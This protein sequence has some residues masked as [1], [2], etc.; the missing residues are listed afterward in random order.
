VNVVHTLRKLIRTTISTEL[1]SAVPPRLPREDG[2]VQAPTSAPRV[3]VV[4]SQTRYGRLLDGATHE[5]VLR[6]Y[7]RL[8][9]ETQEAV[10]LTSVVIALDGRPLDRLLMSGP[11]LP[12]LLTGR[13]QERLLTD[14]LY[15]SPCTIPARSCQERYAFFRLPVPV[16]R[17]WPPLHC[18]ATVLF[19]MYPPKKTA[20]V[21]SW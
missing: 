11:A 17:D 7:L 9:N 4:D 13:G 6:V 21:A 3:E 14:K 15:S 12:I 10:S 19:A 5:Y 16:D 18:T 2:D 20:F 1:P 8:I